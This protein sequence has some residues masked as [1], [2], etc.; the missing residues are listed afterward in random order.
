MAFDWSIT[1][2]IG[3]SEEDEWTSVVNQTT[4]ETD[5]NLWRVRPAIL[6]PNANSNDTIANFGGWTAE[7]FAIIPEEALIVPEEAQNDPEDWT[8]L[9]EPN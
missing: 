9:A 2:D 5:G 4:L 6:N 8:I 1:T 3:S 7:E